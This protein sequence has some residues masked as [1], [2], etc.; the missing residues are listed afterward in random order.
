MPRPR[1]PH[2]HRE[3]TRHGTMV[4]Y[5]RIG[6][7]PRTRIKATYGTSEFDSAYHAAI[8]GETPCLT[9][10]TVSGSLRWLISLYRQS[11]AWRDLALSTRKHREYTFL[12]ILK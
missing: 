12:Q 6:K 1:P 9:D 2:L 5:V 8:A 10:K 7:G 4:W 3:A 11:S